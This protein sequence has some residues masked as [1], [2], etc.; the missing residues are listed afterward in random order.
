MD[1]INL[2]LRCSRSD[3]EQAEAMRIGESQG[4][5]SYRT[6]ID[7]GNTILLMMHI[8]GLGHSKISRQL[9]GDFY[10]LV[11]CQLRGTSDYNCVCSFSSSRFSKNNDII[12]IS[13]CNRAVHR[14]DVY[15]KVF[16]FTR[17]R[18]GQGNIEIGLNNDGNIGALRNASTLKCVATLVHSDCILT[19][20]RSSCGLYDVFINNKFL[21][22]FQNRCGKLLII[23]RG[24]FRQFVLYL[25]IFRNNFCRGI[26]CLHD[27]IDITIL[28]TGYGSI[29]IGKVCSRIGRKIAT[30]DRNIG[31]I[32]A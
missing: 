13:C 18:V 8:K 12:C 27:L 15:R 23:F 5:V 32:I 21:E 2:C 20:H 17:S 24:I 22:F 10:R 30:R 19:C 4:I 7:I 6:L 11:D 29:I 1:A 3:G 9:N 26:R 25:G 16:L 28:I 14:G 31:R